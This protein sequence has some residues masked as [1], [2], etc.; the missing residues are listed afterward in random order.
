MEGLETLAVLLENG[1]VPTPLVDMAREGTPEGRFCDVRLSEGLSQLVLVSV[2]EAESEVGDVPRAFKWLMLCQK[3]QGYVSGS[4][5]S[6]KSMSKPVHSTAWEI[7]E[8]GLSKIA[9]VSDK[10][11]HSGVKVTSENDS[12]SFA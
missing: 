2:A 5:L 4:V 3:C 11:M 7:I 10:C 12:V 1:I 8:I 9:L 6:L